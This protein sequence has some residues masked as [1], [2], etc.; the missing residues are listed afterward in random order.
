MFLFIDNFDSFSHILAD[1]VR[2]CDVQLKIVRNDVS[3][4]ELSR[5]TY[6]GVILSPGPGIPSRAGYLME[7][8]EYYHDKL[9]VLGICQGHQAIGEFFGSRL[10][11]SRQPMHGK[12]T[13]VIRTE[14][15]PILEGLPDRFK[16][17]RYHSL[18]LKELSPVL[19]TILT[20]ENG[21]VMALSHKSYPIV[22]LQ[23]HPEAYLTAYGL[24]I[25]QNWTRG[26][27]L[28]AEVKAVSKWTP[29]G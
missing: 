16:V 13:E 12:I 17:T 1:Y 23:F 3:V 24:K 9:P 8:L 5:A 20:T 27:C 29:V 7:I 25:I 28:K 2:Q 14:S 11:K 10:G 15:H 21:E 19:E 6:K 18:E 22:G 4:A 26:I